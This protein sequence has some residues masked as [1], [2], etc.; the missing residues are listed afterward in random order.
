MRRIQLLCSLAGAA[1]VLS[2][3]PASAVPSYTVAV[4]GQ[5]ITSSQGTGVAWDD[6]PNFKAKA[7]ASAGR[8]RLAVSSEVTSFGYG[9]AF[10][11]SP[12][13]LADAGSD[14]DDYSARWS[15]EALDYFDSQGMA[16]PTVATADV[17]F[18]V[19]GLLN[20]TGTV[21]WGGLYPGASFMN[22]TATAR[23]AG[24]GGAVSADAY[25]QYGQQPQRS[26][27]P[28]G[29]VDCLCGFSGDDFGGY[30]VVRD[31]VLPVTLDPAMPAHFSLQLRLSSSLAVTAGGL[32]QLV[33]NRSFSF[34]LDRAAFVFTDPVPGGA[35]VSS[36]EAL[37]V[38]N[39]FVPEPSPTHLLG[40]ALLLAGLRA[41]PS[42]RR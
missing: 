39:L 3:G 10:S 30:L 14:I 32:G 37:I 28:A 11:A 23:V 15:V 27:T 26:V 4:P 29:A 20:D 17:Y 40:L 36:P 38:D 13:I 41:R 18:S 35:L 33:A 25:H 19:H 22:L 1:L 16:I 31:A 9:P 21:L 34:P 2:Q 5:S 12:P 6:P 7:S 42:G 8:R 24:Q